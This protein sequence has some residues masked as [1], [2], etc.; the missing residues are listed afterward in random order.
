MK[1][2][3]K[4]LKDDVLDE[5]KAIEETL[6][7]LNEVKHNFSAQKK[8]DY[9]SEPAMGTYLMNFYN[10]IENIMKRISRLYYLSMPKG[11]N[12]HKELLV[13]SLNPPTGKIPLFDQKIVERII[14]YRNFRHRFVSGYGFQLKAEKMMGLVNNAESLWKDIN[15][16]ISGFWEKL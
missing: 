13:L 4:E 8:N 11:N 6:K 1:D 12:W 5:G 9:I 16:A 7:R 2:E 14:P 15:E 3:Y 10:G